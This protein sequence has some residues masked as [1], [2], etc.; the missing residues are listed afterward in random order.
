MVMMRT[1]GAA[2]FA[3][4]MAAVPVAA[5]DDGEGAAVGPASDVLIE[6]LAQAQQGRGDR[7][8]PYLLV[9]M[10]QALAAQD[11]VAFLDLVDPTYFNEQFAFLAGSGG[12]PGEVL[13]QFVC[14]FLQICDVSKKYRLKDVV[15]A[16]VLSVQPSG[17]RVIVRLEMQM[18]DGV[19]VAGEILYNPGSYRFEAGRG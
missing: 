7:H 9:R 17:D 12:A 3:I 18:W 10:K 11:M 19:M 8:L 6:M 16:H 4:A 1:F 13:N 15:S 14:E 5:Q 2:A